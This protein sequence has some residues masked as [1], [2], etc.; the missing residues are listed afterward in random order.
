MKYV[1]VGVNV[2]NLEASI[3][4]YQKVFGLAPV[5][6]KE[7]Y[8]KFLIEN[9]GLNFTLNVRDQVEGN[10]I[11]HF[12]FQVE[13]SEEILF[14]KERLEKEGFFAREEMDTTCC[15]AVQDKFWVTDPDGNEWEFFYT[16][17]D[18][19]VQKIENTSCC[20]TSTESK[21]NSCC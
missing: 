7:G 1:H 3:A 8:A 11:N 10:Q 18:S 4:F 13:T 2:T 6:V 9:P 20:N 15:Y 14:H 16:K 19:E 12:G 17:A 21:V 5:K